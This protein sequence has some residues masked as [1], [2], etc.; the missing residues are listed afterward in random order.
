METKVLIA[1]I[2]MQAIL[3]FILIKIIL[4]LQKSINGVTGIFGK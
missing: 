4:E 3:L 1:S 2:I